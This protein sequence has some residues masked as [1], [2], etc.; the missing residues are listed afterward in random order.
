MKTYLQFIRE[1]QEVTPPSPIKLPYLSDKIQ[2]CGKWLYERNGLNLQYILDE[3]FIKR[4]WRQFPSQDRVEKYRLDVE[5]L[6]SKTSIPKHIIDNQLKRLDP[7]QPNAFTLVLDER[8]DWHPLSKMNTNIVAISKLLS[9]LIFKIV[10]KNRN[11]SPVSEEDKK[12]KERIE[13]FLNDYDAAGRKE[14][15]NKIS[16]DAGVVVEPDNK[17]RADRTEIVREFLAYIKKSSE[18][19]RRDGFLLVINNYFPQFDD[20][21]NFVKTIERTTADG[22]YAEEQ[23]KNFLRQKGIEIKYEG[24]EGDFI[25][26]VFGCDLIISPVPHVYYLDGSERTE[27]DKF[28][29]NYIT[30]QVKNDLQKSKFYSYNTQGNIEVNPRTFQDYSKK[31]IDWICQPNPLEFFDLKTMK[32]FEF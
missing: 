23:I 29:K 6:L 31:G 16:S 17:R 5:N 11:F 20:Y 28:S 18:E 13:K 24:K 27:S 26:M 7:N 4:G 19:W 3:I 8:G 22:N 30:I 1:M 21:K 25:D 32:K 9:E 14:P 15:Q 2:G 10:E 12:R